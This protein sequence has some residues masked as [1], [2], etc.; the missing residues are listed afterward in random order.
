MGAAAEALLVS[1][2]ENPFLG[3]SA[4]YK[5]IG[6]DTKKGTKAKAELVALGLV[7]EVE[8][9][10]GKRGRNPKLLELTAD[11]RAALEDRGQEVR[12]GAKGG[13][14]HQWWQQKVKDYYEEQGYDTTI[15]YQLG[16]K[17]IDVYA[18]RADDVVAV[19]MR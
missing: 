16:K 14:E 12:S 9:R 1:V 10:T 11:G 17:S 3:V 18:V 6:V 4:R 19:E 5:E 2:N 7:R 8:V 13:I 15:E